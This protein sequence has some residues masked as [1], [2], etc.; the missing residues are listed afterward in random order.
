MAVRDDKSTVT[1]ENKQV[2]IILSKKDASVISVRTAN[3][4]EV[5]RESTLFINLTDSEW[6]VFENLSLKAVGDTLILTTEVGRVEVEVLT[7]DGYFILECKTPLPEKAYCMNFGYIRYDYDLDDDTAPRGVG[8]A[9]TVSVDP[10][11]FPD[12]IRRETYAKLYE[13]LGE[14]A[15]GGRY[16]LAV[17]PENIR[18]ETLREI[19]SEIDSERGIVLKSAGPWSDSNALAR[20]SYAK[21]N[22]CRRSTIEKTSE[23]YRR[24]GVDQVFFQQNQLNTFH[25]GNFKYVRYADDADFKAQ[26]TDY[27]NSKGIEVGLHTYAQYINNECHDILSQPKYQEMLEYGEEFTLAEDIS[28]DADFIP[29]VESTAGVSRV[30][31]FFEKNLPF[32]LIGNEFVKYTNH[33]H[34][35]AT[36]QRGFC[37]TKAVAHKKGEKIRH[38]LGCFGKLVPLH[39]SELFLMIARNTANAFNKG[40]YSMIYL[41]AIDGTQKHVRKEERPYY[42]ARFVH[43]IIKNCERE[44]LLELSDMPASVWACRARMGA[45][46][47]PYRNY[48]IFNE[49]HHKD[50]LNNARR[51]YHSTL[52]WYNYF[53]IDEAYPANQHTRYQHTDDIDHMGMLSLLYGYSTVFN[54][55]Y[56]IDRYYGCYRNINHYNLYI[57]LRREKYFSDKTLERA[58][59]CNSELAVV[60]KDGRYKIVERAYSKNRL[61]GIDGENRRETLLENPFKKQT[62]FVR[63]EAGMSSLGDDSL[64]LLPLNE[65]IP[66]SSQVKRLD[67]AGALDLRDKMAIKVR[68]KG[69]GKKGHVGIKLHAGMSTGSGYGLYIIDTDFEGWRDFT[70]V[71][72]DNGSRVEL[73]FEK[74]CHAYQ[75]HRHF[76]NLAGVTSVELMTSGD[77]GEVYM[78]GVTA[79]RQVYDVLKNPTVTV[80]DES[81]TFEC[82]LKSTDL[83]EWDGKSAKVIDR[84]ANENKI[85]FSGSLTVPHGKYK[86]SLS[87]VSLNGCPINAVLTVGTTGKE[88]K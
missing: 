7:R 50:N 58:R 2:K 70:L 27:L 87:A 66:V 8:V 39:N 79:C 59:E 28:A 14:G 54:G 19:C 86:S 24:I 53:P 74:G 37:G 16:A 12:G 18:V 5:M 84:Y 1:L 61:Y 78:T 29:T 25:Q 17:L 48:K 34:G 56:D 75:L 26:V 81:V 13:H 49:L 63:I 22:D 20:G 64:L 83:I 36:C 31:G 21:A 3:G 23:I 65:T 40:G 88:V 57:R 41:D 68:V 45:W 60:E 77:V 55:G 6:N 35:F 76:F 43:E 10:R 9:M 80:G 67:F 51:C 72:T 11:Y 62:P 47:M 42:I 38:A 44:P 4:V 30:Y 32:A 71:E 46:D 85:Y 69:N 82:E 73:G 15:K 33:D 52:G